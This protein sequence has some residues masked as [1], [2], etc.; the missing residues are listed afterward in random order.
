MTNN[1][2]AYGSLIQ[3]PIY[4]PQFN[5]IKDGQY[6]FIQITITDQNLNTVE[7]KDSNIIIILQF[8]SSD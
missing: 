2:V 5:S 6:A 3:T 4:Y 7:L 8:K 1:D